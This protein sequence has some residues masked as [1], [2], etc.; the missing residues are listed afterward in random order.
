MTREISV[1]LNGLRSLGT[2]AELEEAAA[3][4]DIPAPARKA[5]AHVHLPPN[6]S[7]FRSIEQ[8]VTLA[9]AQGLRIL[10][11]S[12]Y[13]DF[14]IYADFAAR[15]RQHGIYPL[16]GLEIIALLEDLRRASLLVND[17]GNPGRMYICGKGITR[18]APMSPAA[19]NLMDWIRRSDAE[20][21]RRMVELVEQAFRCHGVK[22][23]LNDERIRDG[24]THRFKVDRNAVCIQERHIAEAF[25]EAFVMAVPPD[26]RGERLSAIL[27]AASK[28]GPEDHLK[29]QQEI[30]SCLMKVGKPAFVPEKFVDFGQA[31]RLVLEL[32]GIPC[33][34]TLADGASPVC[35]FEDPPERLIEAL[36]R[37]RVFCAEFIPIRNEPAVL[38]HYVRALRA[39]GI[40]VTGGTEHNTPDLLPLEPECVRGQPVPDAIREIFWEGACV[41]VAH[42]YLCLNGLCGYVDANGSLNPEFHGVED[43]ISAFAR[44]G[45]AVLTRYHEVPAEKEVSSHNG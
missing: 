15:A 45:A 40:V 26:R 3:R 4:A 44:L 10:G 31:Y 2:P 13:Y 43:R 28:A 37:R 16:F 41:V 35:A 23:G 42:Q 5:N 24:I 7:A 18:F 21:M 22:T 27:G 32:G 38:E 17:P 14:G 1:S 8:A 20:R 9:H 19:G 25:Q 12:N 29:M 34:P 36:Q 30:R 33:Y 11:V 39:A 6:F